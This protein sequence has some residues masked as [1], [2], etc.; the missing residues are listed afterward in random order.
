M[1]DCSS[2]PESRAAFL[3]PVVRA[4]HGKRLR[5]GPLLPF[6]DDFTAEDARRSVAL[7][8]E[9]SAANKKAKRKHSASF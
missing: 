4:T 5:T 9:Q 7:H 8:D 6:L 3:K 1:N 2:T